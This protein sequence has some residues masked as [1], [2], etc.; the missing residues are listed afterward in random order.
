MKDGGLHEDFFRDVNTSDVF[1]AHVCFLD[2]EGAFQSKA[3]FA[4]L[5]I[6]FFS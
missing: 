3:V 4:S 6:Y 5:V 2:N 1:P